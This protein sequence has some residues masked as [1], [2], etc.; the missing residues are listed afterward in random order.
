MGK[1][2]RGQEANSGRGNYT[3]EPLMKFW[4]ALGYRVWPQSCLAPGPDKIRGVWAERVRGSKLF[5][6]CIY[7]MQP[8]VPCYL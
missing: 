7:D 1:H 4:G 6:L 3:P 5:C 2:Q 8:L